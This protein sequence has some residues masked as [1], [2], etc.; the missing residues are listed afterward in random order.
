[1]LKHVV[2]FRFKDFA[3][4]ADKAENM[5]RLKSRLEALDDIID[6]IEFFEVGKNVI[7]S[8]AAYDLALYSQFESKEDLFSYQKH[9][10]HVK[11]ADFVKK[12]CESR[13]VVDYI[14]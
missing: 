2:L 1:M 14:A 10:E 3:E 4:G 13:V 11:V 7:N 5:T 9:P 12:I 6:E 8:D